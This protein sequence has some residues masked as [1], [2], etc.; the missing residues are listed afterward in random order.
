MPLRLRPLTIAEFLADFKLYDSILIAVA[1]ERRARQQGRG[2]VLNEEEQLVY[3][4][5]SVDLDIIDYRLH[6]LK[7]IVPQQESIFATQQAG[8]NGYRFLRDEYLGRHYIH[9]TRAQDDFYWKISIDATGEGRS[10]VLHDYYFMSTNGSLMDMLDALKNV[11]HLFPRKEPK[12]RPA[13][14]EGVS[15]ATTQLPAFQA[16]MAAATA[17]P[18]LEEEGHTSAADDSEPDRAA[19]S[20]SPPKKLR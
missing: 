14:S 20:E 8:E 3:H 12:P 18:I 7:G 6:S 4:R 11:L 9:I 15:D 10:A 16:A 2:T 17:R 1:E 5:V 13:A 19:T